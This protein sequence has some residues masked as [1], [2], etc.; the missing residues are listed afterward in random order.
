MPLDR[1]LHF[2]IY[3]NFISN[4]IGLFDVAYT[5]VVKQSI[6]WERCK[7]CTIAYWLLRFASLHFEAKKIMVLSE[8]SCHKKYIS[9]I[10]KPYLFLFVWTYGQ[11]LSFSKVVKPQVKVTHYGATCMWKILSQGIHIWYMKALSVMTV[12]LWLRQ[13]FLPTQLTLTLTRALWHKLPEHSSWLAKN[14]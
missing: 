3:Q 2:I 10:W 11:D 14:T 13:K 4:L 9:V 8:R 6:P 1:Y 7:V 12:K 5:V